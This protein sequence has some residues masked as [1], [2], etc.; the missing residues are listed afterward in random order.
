MSLFFKHFASK[1]QLPGTL[2]ENGLK[3]FLSPTYFHF[4]KRIEEG[5]KTVFYT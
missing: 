5:G 2:V 4:T 1:N 3:S